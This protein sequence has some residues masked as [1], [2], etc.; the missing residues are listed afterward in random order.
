MTSKYNKMAH[1]GLIDISTLLCHKLNNI[2]FNIT[3]FDDKV[4][5]CENQMR[6]AQQKLWFI[7]P[8]CSMKK[9]SQ[10]LFF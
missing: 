7:Y 1:V 5:V 9:S 4:W 6:H 2:V 10:I 8:S 3:V